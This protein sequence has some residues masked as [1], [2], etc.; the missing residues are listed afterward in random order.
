MLVNGGFITYVSMMKVSINANGVETLTC[1]S[2]TFCSAGHH[3]TVSPHPPPLKSGHI[4]VQLLIQIS[5]LLSTPQIGLLTGQ[6]CFSF[7]FL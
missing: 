4:P 7:F 3:A 1:S 6:F 2:M 5:Y